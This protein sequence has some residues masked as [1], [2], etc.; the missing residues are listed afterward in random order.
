MSSNDE[1][2]PKFISEENR[3]FDYKGWPGFPD[4][5]YI[6]GSYVKWEDAKFNWDEN[7]YTWDEVRYV[8][9]L[10]SGKSSSQ[11]YDTLKKDKEERKRFIKLVCKVKGIETYSGKKTIDEDIAITV[12]DIKLV[13]KEVLKVDLMVENINV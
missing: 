3:T 11:V 8:I 4:E 12:E 9:I 1:Y 13:V 2:I 6:F 7:P 5:D 10:T